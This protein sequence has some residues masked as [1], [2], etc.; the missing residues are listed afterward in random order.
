MTLQPF[1]IAGNK[2]QEIPDV[3]DV[4]PVD[5]QAYQQKNRSKN[6]IIIIIITTLIAIAATIY[7][8]YFPSASKSRVNIIQTSENSFGDRFFLLDPLS[9]LQRG[10]YFDKLDFGNS[11]CMR[12]ESDFSVDCDKEYKLSRIVVDSGKTFQETIGFGGAFTEASAFNFYNLPIHVQDKVMELYFGEDGIGL[13]LGRIHINS[14]DFSLE[15][16]SFDDVEDDFDLQYFDSNVTHDTKAI[17]PFIKAAM[18][19]SSSKINLLASPWSPP[20]WMKQS[21]NGIPSMLGSEQPQ[22]LSENPKIQAAWALYFSKF[23]EAYEKHGV[24]IWAVTPQNE[25]E[26]AAVSF[27]LSLLS[28]KIKLI[29]DV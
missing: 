7:A 24:P 18:A 29:F 27:T 21:D 8:E 25:P 9:L 11:G 4:T 19:K 28:R 20:A 1:S 17:I 14:C 6:V 5:G 12:H 10:F 3:E 13:T 15:S 16:Y 26:F 2:Y 22:G 23:I